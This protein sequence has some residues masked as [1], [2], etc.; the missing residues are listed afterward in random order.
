ME[1]GKSTERGWGGDEGWVEMEENEDEDNVKKGENEK[2]AR[3]EKSKETRGE[4]KG[5][6]SRG[7]VCSLNIN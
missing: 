1:E 6:E 7:K 5:G 3:W 2:Q 4:G